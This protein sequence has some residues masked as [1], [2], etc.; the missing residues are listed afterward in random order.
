[1]FVLPVA[2]AYH[3]TSLFILGNHVA[4]INL[5]KFVEWLIFVHVCLEVVPVVV[6]EDLIVLIL[7]ACWGGEQ[8]RV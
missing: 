4:P 6:D 3:L 5:L 1:M 7:F 8:S 2:G